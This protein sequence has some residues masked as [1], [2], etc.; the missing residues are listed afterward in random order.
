MC[1]GKVRRRE[2]AAAGKTEEKK[3]QLVFFYKSYIIFFFCLTN[4]ATF[5]EKTLGCSKFVSLQGEI[6]NDIHQI[7]S[8]F[9]Q[10]R[11]F[12]SYFFHDKIK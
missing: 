1:T 4:T 5:R 2:T 12:I 10:K 3:F 9:C 6:A 8:C 7:F 11:I